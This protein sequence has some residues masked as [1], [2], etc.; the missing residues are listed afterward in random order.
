VTD[1]NAFLLRWVGW[2][3]L[4]ESLGFLAPALAQL[5][6]AEMW[7]AAM[8]PLLV[9]AGSVEGAVLGWFQVKVLR[10]RLP[11]VSVRRWVLRAP[12]GE[13]GAGPGGG[14]EATAAAQCNPALGSGSCRAPGL[15][16]CLA[17]AEGPPP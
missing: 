12:G 16:W 11:A 6:A 3:S 5:M 14:R 2:V 7:P 17:Y 13:R 8:V 1:R 9:I 15:H 10:T 4:G